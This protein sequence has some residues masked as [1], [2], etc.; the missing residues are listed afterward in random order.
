MRKI[1]RGSA[2]RH[3]RWC[4]QR[5]TRPAV[6]RTALIRDAFRL[7][8]LTIG[9]MTPEA[10][11][12]L[13]AGIGAGSLVLVAFGL[14][15]V[16]ELISAGVLMW[17]LSTELR[18][19]QAFSEGCRTACESDWRRFAVRAR[20]VRSARGGLESLGSAWPRV[21]LGRTRSHDSG[22]PD[23]ALPRSS[24]DRSCGQTG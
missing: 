13:V 3:R 16:I 22:D 6:E 5:P 18:H 12:A 23:Y 17:R 7:E 21:F 1:A 8:W 15:S 4:C 10:V 11:V 19:G 9:W 2:A 24:K 14:D 20:D